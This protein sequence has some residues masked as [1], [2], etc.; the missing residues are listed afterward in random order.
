MP[1]ENEDCEIF[2]NVD[3]Q[4][5]DGKIFDTLEAAYEFYNQYALLNGFGT[6][7]HNAHKIRA[8]GAIFRRQFVC[9]KE[10]FMKLDDKRSNV[11]E[12]RRRDLRAGCEAVMQK[13]GACVVNKFHDFHNHALTTTPSNG[14]DHRSHSKD[15]RTNVCKS[16][17]SDH[18]H[19]GLKASQ[20]T[21]V[22]NVMKPC[23]EAGITPRQCSSLIRIERKNNVRKEYYVII[24]HFQEKATYA[25]EDE[26]FKTMNSRAVLSSDLPIEAKAEEYYTRSVFEIF[27]KEWN[28]SKVLRLLVHVS[29]FE[30][31]GILCKHMLY[32][33][34]KKKINDL[35]KYFI[36]P[37][38]TIH[39]RYKIS[40]RDLAA[41]IKTKGHP[42]VATTL[43]Y[44][45]ELAKEEKKQRT[46]AYCHEKGHYRTS[47]AKRK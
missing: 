40:I 17:V 42:K 44:S 2:D 34:K 30:K 36:L 45:I 11:N 8:M 21:R 35:P 5:I 27:K 22:V 38:W 47:C 41:P 23:E 6:R 26:D 18:N 19:E 15:N 37:R 29:K 3:S 7:K 16:L 20:I 24:K 25:E 9:N 10:G 13:L 4:Q 31:A 46:C 28:A 1:R 43:K 33:L 12:K 39:A 32:I 14:I